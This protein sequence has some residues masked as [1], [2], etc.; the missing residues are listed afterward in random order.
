[1]QSFLGHQ[2][3]KPEIQSILKDPKAQERER[4]NSNNNKK[5]KHAGKVSSLI[6]IFPSSNP[7]VKI[8]I[9]K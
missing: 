4:S 9:K 8:I 1:M 5:R 2:R 6:V 7:N 3:G